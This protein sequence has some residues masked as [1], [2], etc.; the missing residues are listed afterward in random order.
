M[1]GLVLGDARIASAARATCAPGRG[2]SPRQI[3]DPLLDRQPHEAVPC[4]MKFDF[5]PP[6]P[7]AIVSAEHRRVF[8]RQRAPLDRFGAPGHAAECLELRARPS[9]A[10]ARHRLA[11]R[12]VGGKQVVVRQRRRLIQNFIDHVPILHLVWS[13]IVGPTM[14]NKTAVHR[15]R[16]IDRNRIRRGGRPSAVG[17]RHSA[18][19][20]ARRSRR[21][22]G[23]AG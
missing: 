4:R 9:G 22:S 12:T 7:V 10:F 1:A 13:R 20:G 14:K 21:T 2:H 6:T 16:A 5:V 11:Q 18:R 15:P 23:R 3:V 19:R 8:V 17:L